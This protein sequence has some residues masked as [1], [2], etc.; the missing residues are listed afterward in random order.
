MDLCMYAPTLAAGG[1]RKL[2]L[3][4]ARQAPV[5]A[6][7]C[8]RCAL[9]RTGSDAQADALICY[10]PSLEVEV[11]VSRATLVPQVGVGVV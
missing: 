5:C 7:V 10:A 4:N 3:D 11:G 1:K 8:S 6:C 2:M 9:A